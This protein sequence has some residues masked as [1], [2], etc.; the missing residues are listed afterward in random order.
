MSPS[1]ELSSSPMSRLYDNTGSGLQSGWTFFRNRQV[2][3]FILMQHKRFEWDISLYCFCSNVTNLFLFFSND[4][5]R[6]FCE[7]TYIPSF[8]I[9]ILIW[10]PSEQS[11]KYFFITFSAFF[12]S[13][14]IEPSLLKIRNFSA[15]SKFRENHDLCWKQ[16]KDACFVKAGITINKPPETIGP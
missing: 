5:Q 14:K 7:S 3:G 16:V 1:L 2:G 12:K 13:W 15:G 8:C 10:R 11:Q 6:C 9:L 4:V